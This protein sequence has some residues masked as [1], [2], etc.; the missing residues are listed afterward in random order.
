MIRLLGARTPCFKAITVAIALFLVMAEGAWATSNDIAVDQALIEQGRL[1][2]EKAYQSEQGA[3]PQNHHIEAAMQEATRFFHALQSPSSLLQET[4]ARS[5]KTKNNHSYKVLVFASYALGERGLNDLL[6][7]VA[8]NASAVLVFRGIPKGMSLG[9]GIQAI[10]AL[11]TRKKPI[12]S[13]VI[14]PTLFRKYRVTTVHTIVMLEDQPLLGKTPKTLASVQGLS[15]L[16][17]LVR[18]LAQGVTGDQGIKGP[19]RAISEPDLIE[20]MKERFAAIDWEAKKQ[21]VK[22]K[23]WK[24]QSFHPLPLATHSQTRFIDPSVALKKDITG[25]DGTMIA[26]QGTVMNPLDR[27]SF[28]QAVVVF[29]PID[30]RQLEWL[31][32][33]IPSLKNAPA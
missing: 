19:I 16:T 4:Q 3:L 15:N 6:G 31:N 12:P 21:A 25:A 30:K 33:T 17:W 1:I 22:E 13:I 23:V 9:Q 11:A 5:D 2:V 20:V 8:G 10:Q 26:K 24:M 32:K 7:S 27:R 18:Q 14:D 29:D 28:T